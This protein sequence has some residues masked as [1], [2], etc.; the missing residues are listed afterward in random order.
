VTERVVLVGMMGSGKTTVGQLLAAR[1]GVA[2]VDSDEQVEAAT[3]RTV[4]EIWET[5]GEGAFRAEE[6]RALERAVTQPG[7]RVVSVA[8]GG[9]LD[10]GNRKLIASAGT[11]VWLR[12]VA[13]TLIERVTGAAAVGGHRPLLA[14]DPEGTLHRLAAERR[15]LY[16][17]VADVVV[18]VDDLAPEDVVD[19][20][21]EQL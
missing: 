4:R 18:D 8:G 1:L 16:E 9:V 2:Y 10:A 5:D 17:D 21:L 19:R 13:D 14:E 15:D 7:A 11:V 20:I 3:G 6:A 12:A